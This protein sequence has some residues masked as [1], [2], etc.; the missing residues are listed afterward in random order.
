MNNLEAQKQFKQK[1]IEQLEH[2]IEWQRM[3]YGDD[4]KTTPLIILGIERALRSVKYARYI[5]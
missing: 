1:L 4:D 3:A 5:K 2:D